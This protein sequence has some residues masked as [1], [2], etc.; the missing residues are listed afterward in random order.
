LEPVWKQNWGAL[1]DPAAQKLLHMSSSWDANRD[2]TFTFFGNP[3]F[4]VES[5]PSFSSLGSISVAYLKNGIAA[6]SPRGPKTFQPK[7]ISFQRLQR[8]RRSLGKRSIAFFH[9]RE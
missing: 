1:V 2:P 6:A 9:R 8:R 4:F 3:N 7:L 5:P